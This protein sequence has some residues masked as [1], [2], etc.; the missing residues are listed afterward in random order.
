MKRRRWL[1]VLVFAVAS[2]VAS[3]QVRLDV[4]RGVMGTSFRIV[5]CADDSAQ[6]RVALEAAFERI[7]ALDRVL[8]D[9]DP[10]SEV[11][12]IAGQE[13]GQP[14]TVSGDLAAVL[15]VSASWWVRTGGI[16]D[17]ALGALTRLWRRAVR[18]NEVPS[19]RD[20]DSALAQSGFRLL[21]RSRNGRSVTRLAHG[22]R[23]D[24]GGIGKGYAA[25]EALRV[26]GS[27]GIGAAI[28]DAGGDV[29]AGDPPD[30][31]DGWRVDGPQGRS[32]WV[33]GG[34]IATS[35][36]TWHHVETDS[37]RYS[38]IID[39]RT[40]LGVTGH[41]MVTVHA[42]R[43][44]DA[45]ALASAMSVLSVPEAI[46]LARAENVGMILDE[47]DRHIVVGQWPPIA[48]ADAR[49]GSDTCRARSIE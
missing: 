8:S 15:A 36:A 14:V 24:F 31:A 9:Y 23:L 19:S 5:A 3:A 49:P 27:K 4:T 43:G 45:D 16:F 38:H 42:R 30:G 32:W 40:G 17:P 20:I 35:G 28:V 21:D 6:G 26:L 7:A 41:R 2:P 47:P 1:V 12:R 39:P 29:T 25:D 22:V 34:S 18:R 10:E 13:V 48:P 11:S 44:A 37:V 33:K 46:A